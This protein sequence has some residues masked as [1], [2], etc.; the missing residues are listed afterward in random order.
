M[1]FGIRKLICGLLLGCAAIATVEGADYR[2]LDFAI[3]RGGNTEKYAPVFDFDGDG[4]LPAAGISR[5]GEQ[6]PGIPAS[7]WDDQ[8]K[9]AY[10]RDPAFLTTS[11]ILHRYACVTLSGT[12]A[13]MPFWFIHC[14]HFYSLYFEKDECDLVTLGACGHTHDWEYV[15]VWTMATNYPGTDPDLLSG[16]VTHVCA[17]AHGDCNPWLA[18]DV[19]F[20]G[21]HP[22]IVYHQ[23]NVTTHAM[24]FAGSNDIAN[25]ENPYGTFV[26]PPLVS[27]YEL[28]GNVLS[29]KAMRDLLNSFNYG[30]ATIPLKD[31]IFL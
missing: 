21:E 26:T 1:S 6:N 29:N 2:G 17:S 12:T 9:G 16:F 19:P 27:W 11:N 28:K 25:P 14:G 18:S 20:E 23:E 8:G 24:R 22:M 7:V 4:C 3:P 30:N 31:G 13:E 15:A 10:C 5:D